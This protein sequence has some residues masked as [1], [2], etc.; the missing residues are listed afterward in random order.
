[1]KVLAIVLAAIFGAIA[2]IYLI[3]GGPLGF[4][5]KHA[6]LF[7]ALSGLSWVWLRFQSRGASAPNV[8]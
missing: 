8:R 5:V 6:I 2:I 4:H 1:M 7:V 3:P